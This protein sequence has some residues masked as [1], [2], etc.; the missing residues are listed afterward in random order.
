[1]PVAVDAFA[2]DLLLISAGFD[3]HAWDPLAQL[4]LTGAD[5]EWA[6]RQLARLADRHCDGKIVSVLEGGYDA[7]GLAEGCARHLHALV[8]A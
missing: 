2:P 6:T 5:F 8:R 3:A 4:Q 7:A 1:M